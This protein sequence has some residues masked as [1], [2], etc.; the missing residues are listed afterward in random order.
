LFSPIN[1]VKLLEIF[2]ALSG[3]KVKCQDISN[4]ATKLINCYQNHRTTFIGENK[5]RR[6]AH[7]KGGSLHWSTGK[8]KSNGN[9]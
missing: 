4:Y 5:Q 9:F 2:K 6:T 8:A 1:V 7:A 3:G